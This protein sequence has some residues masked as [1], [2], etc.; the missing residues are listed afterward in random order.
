MGTLDAL[1]VLSEDLA[2]YDGQF[3]AATNKVVDALRSAFKGDESRVD[4]ACRI[5][6]RMSHNGK[7]ELTIEQPESYIIN[8][9]CMQFRYPLRL[10]IREFHE[11]SR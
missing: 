1:I 5:A 9:Q 3:E 8:Y 11:I 10:M 7:H 6:D 4:F 2:K